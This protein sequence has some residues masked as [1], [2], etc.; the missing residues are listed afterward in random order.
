VIAIHGDYDPHPYQGVKE[1]L[2]IILK[3]FRFILL[4]KCEHEPW[5]E[6]QARDKFFEI[7][8]GELI[9]LSDNVR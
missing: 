2:S 1:P 4:E 3:I 5:T 9:D 6:R 8:E 7:I